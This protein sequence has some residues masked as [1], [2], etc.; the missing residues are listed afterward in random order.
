M[1]THLTVET[2]AIPDHTFQIVALALIITQQW[3]INMIYLHRTTKTLTANLREIKTTR[4]LL[5]LMQWVGRHTT[6]CWDGCGHRGEAWGRW[7]MW[8][9][10][11]MACLLPPHDTP[12]LS[13]TTSPILYATPFTTLRHVCLF[14]EA[15]RE[16]RVFTDKHKTSGLSLDSHQIRNYRSWWVFTAWT[17]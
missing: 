2:N 12:L 8:G 11:W 5:P 6:T 7:G 4:N 1:T 16:A 15:S 10:G 3:H 13:K 9:R 17:K 14:L